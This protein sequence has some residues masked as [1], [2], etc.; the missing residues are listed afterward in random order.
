MSDVVLSLK[1]LF[2]EYV[3]TFNA[4]EV[5]SDKLYTARQAGQSLPVEQWEHLDK[6]KIA[7]ESQLN[8]RIKHAGFSINHPRTGICLDNGMGVR[9]TADNIHEVPDKWAEHVGKPLRERWWQHD[10]PVE[11]VH[12]EAK[13][14]PETKSEP[15]APKD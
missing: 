12:G 6:H 11:A 8:E 3:E 15:V 4:H 9:F 1:E 7:L 10:S 13:P 2:K 14:A 5:E